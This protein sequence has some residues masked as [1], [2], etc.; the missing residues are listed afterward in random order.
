MPRD[1]ALDIAG[2][3]ADAL[4]SMD[5]LFLRVLFLVSPALSRGQ[6]DAVGGTTVV[7]ALGALAFFWQPHPTLVFICHE[8]FPPHSSAKGTNPCRS[9][10]RNSSSLVAASLVLVLYSRR[11]SVHSPQSYITMQVLCDTSLTSSRGAWFTS[12]RLLCLVPYSFFLSFE[13]RWPR[14]DCSAVI[15]ASANDHHLPGV[16]IHAEKEHL[17]P[18]DRGEKEP[19]LPAALQ[20][21]PPSFNGQEFSQTLPPRLAG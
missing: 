17:P 16:L 13:N 4:I 6:T 20:L 2:I 11:Q 5:L 18:F 12:Y 3:T 9:M 8:L 15:T 7:A 10:I 21:V 19:Y 1:P 14:K